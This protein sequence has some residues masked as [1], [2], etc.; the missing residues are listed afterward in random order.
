VTSDGHFRAGKKSAPAQ[1][2]R[3]AFLEILFD[4]GKID[5]TRRVLL[6]NQVECINTLK[7]DTEGCDLEVLKG[8]SQMREL[9]SI[10]F[11]YVEFNDDCECG[12]DI[13]WRISAELGV[14]VRGELYRLC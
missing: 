11:T 5:S 2:R 7:I 13:D 4:K 8:A 3:F 14:S 12:F 6:G 9:A 1:K 10:K